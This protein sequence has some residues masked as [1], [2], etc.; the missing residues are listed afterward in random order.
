VL[1]TATL[2]AVACAPSEDHIQDEIDEANHCAS[3]SECVD[4]GTHCPFGCNI[5]VHASEAA[6]IRDLLDDHEE[7]CVYDCMAP[8]TIECVAGRCEMA[9]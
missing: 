7:S 1:L 9:Q 4:V 6:R 5:L 2:L 8:T 3:A